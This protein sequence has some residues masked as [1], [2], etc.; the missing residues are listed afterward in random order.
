[1]DYSVYLTV[2]FLFGAISTYRLTRL[3]TYDQVSFQIRLWIIRR[4]KPTNPIAYFIQ[5]PWC[6]SIWIGAVVALYLI[7]G[8]DLSWMMFTPMV[9]VFSAVTGFL[10]EKYDT[11]ED[12]VS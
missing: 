11:E 2:M 7:L 5:C 9:L 12:E 10:A 4:V 3:A 8:L 6:M 1:M